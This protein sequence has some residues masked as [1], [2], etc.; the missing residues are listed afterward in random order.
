MSENKLPAFDSVEELAD[1]FD[2]TD[3]GDFDLPEAHF[4]VE[5]RPQN[6]ILVEPQLLAR[7]QN[8]AA[9]R[10]VTREALINEWLEE[11]IAQVA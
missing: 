2:R 7:V 4:E 5:L 10:Q 1:F 11:K 9:K 8:I 3:M 6:A